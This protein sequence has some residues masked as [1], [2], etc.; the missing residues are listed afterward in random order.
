[1]PRLRMIAKITA[2]FIF[3]ILVVKI[4]STTPP[5]SPLEPTPEEPP[6]PL[7]EPEPEPP[8]ELTDDEMME[9]AMKKEWIWKDFTTYV[10]R[11]VY[12]V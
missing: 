4:M 9:I 12:P 8:K 5:P 10:K 6:P 2:T 3:L 11:R 7:P 1:M